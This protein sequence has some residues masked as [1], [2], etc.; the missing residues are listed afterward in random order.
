MFACRKEISDFRVLD[1]FDRNE[2]KLNRSEENDNC[3]SLFA[4]FVVKKEGK[5]SIATGKITNALP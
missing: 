5:Q 4:K 2:I 3:N 1:V